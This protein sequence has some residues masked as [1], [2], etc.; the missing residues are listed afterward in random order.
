VIPRSD[1]GPDV[2]V[3]IEAGENGIVPLTE[4]LAR[5]WAEVDLVAGRPTWLDAP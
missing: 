4:G 5:Y 1:T 2:T 3:L